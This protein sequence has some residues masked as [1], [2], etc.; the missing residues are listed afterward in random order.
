MSATSLVSPIATL[1]DEYQA[2]KKGTNAIKELG[3]HPHPKKLRS[4]FN[5]YLAEHGSDAASSLITLG[6]AGLLYKYRHRL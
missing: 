6:A 3:G 2:S 1:V 5:S 4:A